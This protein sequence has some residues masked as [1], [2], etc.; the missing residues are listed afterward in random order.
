MAYLFVEA[1]EADC[2][3]AFVLDS[4]IVFSGLPVAVVLIFLPLIFVTVVPVFATEVN[5][6]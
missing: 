6:A 3:S 1:G 5:G 4:G 2:L